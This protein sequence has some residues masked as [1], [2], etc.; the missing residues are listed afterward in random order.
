MAGED[1]WGRGLHCVS[2]QLCATT[3]SHA[4][5]H[6]VALASLAGDHKYNFYHN[7]C[8]AATRL[9]QRKVATLTAQFKSLLIQLLSTFKALTA[10][11]I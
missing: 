8:R 11:Y 10:A 9:L 7:K 5:F 2:A 3:E 4:S 6:K 1:V